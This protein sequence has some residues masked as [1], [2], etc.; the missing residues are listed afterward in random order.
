MDKKHNLENMNPLIDKIEEALLRMKKF[1]WK[2]IKKKEDHILVTTWWMNAQQQDIYFF[3]LPYK[4]QVCLTDYG[5]TL[6]LIKEK[7]SHII[8]K[9]KG[10]FLKSLF[11]SL[12]VIREG[13]VLISYSSLPN[14]ENTIISF[15]QVLITLNGFALI[16]KW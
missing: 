2:S 6:N 3:I 16:E 13:E 5:H 12:D 7:K 15:T 1:T 4:D 8:S 10:D 14:V 9:R 11:L